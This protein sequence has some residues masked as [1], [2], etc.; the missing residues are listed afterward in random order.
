MFEFK[1]GTKISANYCSEQYSNTFIGTP[2]HESLGEIVFKDITNGLECI[3][4]LD[5]VK[6]KYYNL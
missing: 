6:K 1:D 3:V 5:A 4:K 2:R